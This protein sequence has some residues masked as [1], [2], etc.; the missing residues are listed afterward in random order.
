MTLNRSSTGILTLAL[1]LAGGCTDPA[2][3]SS[4]TD[5]PWDVASGKA[6][7]PGSGAGG[8]FCPR[9]I[10]DLSQADLVAKFRK[11]VS[12]GDRLIRRTTHARQTDGSWRIVALVE[13]EHT[14]KGSSYYFRDTPLPYDD[15]M[16]NFYGVP[17]RLNRYQ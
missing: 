14:D 5:S 7:G 8:G 16:M 13:I 15:W 4:S 12:D 1:V 2:P 3:P 9:G 10:V 17:P 6:D 11:A